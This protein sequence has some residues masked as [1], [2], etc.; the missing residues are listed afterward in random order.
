MFHCAPLPL[1]LGH[2]HSLN[3][4]LGWWP[5]SQRR[6]Q[7]AIGAFKSWCTSR[8]KSGI[9][10][11]HLISH[12]QLGSYFWIIFQNSLDISWDFHTFPKGKLCQTGS[13]SHRS[14]SAWWH[15]ASPRC[16]PAPGRWKKCARRKGQGAQGIFANFFYKMVVANEVRLLNFISKK[17]SCVKFLNF[18]VLNVSW[19][20]FSSER[21]GSMWVANQ[22]PSAL[23]ASWVGLSDGDL[24]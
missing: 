23:P 14:W 24:A 4:A 6:W 2:S 18:T 22:L 1:R 17:S 15:A 11:S 19:S 7:L 9:L 20:H 8:P 16:I 10:V 12:P 21:T 5:S 3:S 13:S